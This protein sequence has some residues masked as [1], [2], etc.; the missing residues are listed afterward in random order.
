[1]E[2]I[3][4]IAKG[5][6]TVL[7]IIW[8]VVIVVAAAGACASLIIA[9]AANRVADAI[10]TGSGS[11]S[12][13]SG[14]MNLWIGDFSVTAGDLRAFALSLALVCVAALVLVLIVIRLA[15]GILSDM[16]QGRPFSENMPILIRR[17]AHVVFA[18]AFLVPLMQLIPSYF[19]FALF[20]I[21]ESVTVSPSVVDAQLTITYSPDILALLISF[22]VYL[23]SFVFAYGAKLQQ[24]SDETL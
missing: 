16:K 19:L 11:F 3:I 4:K 5:L 2:R 20:G 23:L 15:R 9:A 10:N 24:E 12:I 22:V 18:C 21:G 7:F 6:D 14:A 8:V 13:T 1:M 17:I